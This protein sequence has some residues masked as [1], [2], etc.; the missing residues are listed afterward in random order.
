MP[1]VVRQ[2]ADATR[3]STTAFLALFRTHIVRGD[4]L[5]NRSL[6][7]APVTDASA[8]LAA[9]EATLLPLLDRRLIDAEERAR[10]EVALIVGLIAAIIAD[11]RAALRASRAHA[12]SLAP[13]PFG[14]SRI[15]RCTTR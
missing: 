15:R 9:L 3:R 4:A 14:I 6:L 7:L 11:R 12:N 10:R 13:H 2:Q 8:K 1:L 5:Q